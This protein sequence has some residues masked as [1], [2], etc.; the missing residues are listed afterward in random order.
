IIISYPCYSTIWNFSG[1]YRSLCIR[2]CGKWQ[3]Q[4][5]NAVLR[6]VDSCV[7]LR[8]HSAPGIQI[9][10]SAIWFSQRR[11]IEQLIQA[12]GII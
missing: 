4:D 8:H 3:S 7:A 6:I 9:I 12:L 2:E 11:P 1:I 5:G 10:A